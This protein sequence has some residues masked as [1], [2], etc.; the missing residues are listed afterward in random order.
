MPDAPLVLSANQPAA[1][2][3]AGGSR[4]SAFRG[5]APSAPNTPEDWVG[6]TTSVRGNAPV[7]MTVLPDGML[8]ADAIAADPIGWL[9][10]Q[11]LAR[12][13]V[14]EMLLVKLLDPGQRLPVHA[15]PDG[16][17]A[18]THLGAAHGKAEAWYV[19]SAGTVSLGL[20][21]DVAPSRLLELVSAQSTDALLALLNPVDVEPGDTVFVPPG[22]L[23]AIGE[24]V[25]LAEVQEPEDLSILLE[26]TGFDL[27]GT[28]DG[29]LDLGFELALQAVTTTRLGGDELRGLITRGVSEGAA[30][31]PASAPYFRLDR[32]AVPRT[33]PAGLAIVIGLSGTMT[34]HTV[35]GA[36]DVSA[37]MTVLVPAGAGEQLYSGTGAVLVARPPL[38]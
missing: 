1:R 35:A 33:L 37:G 2:F 15:H 17:F 25:L 18:A 30:L 34:L 7:G 13:G 24:G 16:A 22:T 6:S 29:H 38:P 4:I 10:D 20:R 14:D 36:L 5:V 19:L 27:D 12:Y 9:G 26:W 3:Y 28:A 11:H 23:H 8:L 31:V 32:I 21:E